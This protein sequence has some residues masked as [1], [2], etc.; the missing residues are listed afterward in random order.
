M[1]KTLVENIIDGRKFRQTMEDPTDWI[2]EMISIDYFGKPER[3]VIKGF[4]SYDESLVISEED[5]IVDEVSQTIVTLKA[6]YVITIED[7]TDEY[8]LKEIDAKRIEEY[9]PIGEQLDEIYHDIEAWKARIE[10]V[11]LNNPK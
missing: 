11:K 3:T 6:E 2:N 5:V 4:E 7:V 8:N 9:G 10:L 1:K